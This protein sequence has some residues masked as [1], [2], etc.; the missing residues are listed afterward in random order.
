MTDTHQTWAEKWLEETGAH[1]MHYLNLAIVALVAAL[2]WWHFK[3]TQQP[4]GTP[5]IAQSAPQLAH[6]AT[7]AIKPPSVVVYAPVAKKKVPLPMQVQADTHQY[8]LASSRVPFGLHPQN[9]TTVID[10]QTGK[11]TT[12]VTREPLPWIAVQQTGEARIDYGWKGGSAVAR[13]SMREDLLEVKALYLGINATLD[14][15]GQYF[16]GAGVGYKW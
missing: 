12:Y 11:S 16:I 1:W 15:D 7:E 10:D 13:L 4:V 5:A 9:V 14:S 6:V 3:P 8:V 2:L